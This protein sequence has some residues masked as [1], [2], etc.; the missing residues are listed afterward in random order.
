MVTKKVFGLF[1][2]AVS[3]VIVKFCWT[4]FR[5]V[6]LFCKANIVSV[7]LNIGLIKID[8]T[9]FPFVFVFLYCILLFVFW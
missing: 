2:T 8:L 4:R 9:S 7:E 5:A 3:Y 1:T 6:L